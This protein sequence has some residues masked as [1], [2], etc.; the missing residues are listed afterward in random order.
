MAGQQLGPYTLLGRLASGGMGEVYLAAELEAGCFKRYAALKI[1]RDD[2]AVDSQFVDMLID[3]AQITMRI[4]HPNVVAVLDMA[5]SRGSYY[6]AMEYVQGIT[7]E[8]LGRALGDRMD[9]GLALY[10]GS[11]IC[12][13]LEYAH[14]SVDEDGQL[15]GVVHRD[16]TPANILLGVHGEVKLSDFGIARA[17]GRIHQTQA[18]VLKGKF[19]YM[20]PESI[21][22]EAIDRRADL[23]CLGVVLYVI[24]T[25]R[26]PADG[27][28]VLE[29]IRLFEERRIAPPS[30]LNS[31]IPKELDAII[32]RALEP[33]PRNRWSS[34]RHMQA[35]LL[36]LMR[37]DPVWRELDQHGA[38]SLADTIRAVAP[39]ALRPPISESQLET[40]L[41]NRKS[42]SSEEPPTQRHE[43]SAE[44]LAF[45]NDPNAE[46]PPSGSSELVE[47]TIDRELRPSDDY[48]PTLIALAPESEISKTGIQIQSVPYAPGSFADPELSGYVP[49][50][51]P[52]SADD[53][54]RQVFGQTKP[55][56]EP[57]ITASG[58]VLEP[59]PTFH[60]A[61][62]QRPADPSSVPTG[63]R[64]PVSVLPRTRLEPTREPR[65]EPQSPSKNEI[66]TPPEGGAR[67]PG[68][69]ILE[70]RE[71]RGPNA[72][73]PSFPGQSG[74][75]GPRQARAR[76]LQSPE[77]S[78]A[79][80]DIGPAGYAG[81][82]AQA[83][84]S[85]TAPYLRILVIAMLVIALLVGGSAYVF[86]QTPFFWPKLRVSSDPLGSM[87]SLDGKL[88]GLT[89]LTLRIEPG[90][91]HQ[92]KFEQA[93]YQTLAREVGRGTQRG[94]DY[95]LVV[96]LQRLQPELEIS[97]PATVWLNGRIVARHSK[98]LRLIDLPAEGEVAIRIEAE[99]YKTWNMRF[100]SALEVPSELKAELE[101]IPQDKTHRVR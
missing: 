37:S 51:V 85:K 39:A 49:P 53:L 35:A 1:L 48:A 93:G 90:R 13:A 61:P 17:R 57:V 11:E 96:S 4:D 71:G 8:R 27:A 86:F 66:K 50:P 83:T 84:R 99:G 55:L 70:E 28:A 58:A 72:V 52:P 31:R 15:L 14:N 73:Y 46:K 82:G 32:M 78:Q 95:V 101:P 89:P 41:K 44:D 60:K 6:L 69:S 36:Q 91:V 3:E 7:L 45:I 63:P 19:G 18:G 24:L 40:I 98:R 87:L 88:L 77:A 92:V 34:A 30:L 33:Q 67:Q 47:P 38:R 65:T 100:S 97:R 9:V 75:P 74:Q 22:Y 43:V 5:E 64:R 26:H 10:I 81:H 2:L 21:R 79:R 68:R 94:R 54:T 56:P 42:L 80:P 59:K 16:V 23:F 12:S 20:S 62:E 76:A 25:G 29:A